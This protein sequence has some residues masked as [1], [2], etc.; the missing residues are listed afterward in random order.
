M[1]RYTYYWKPV[2]KPKRENAMDHLQSN[3]MISEEDLKVAQIYIC[4]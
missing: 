2:E 3:I 4:Y 1:L